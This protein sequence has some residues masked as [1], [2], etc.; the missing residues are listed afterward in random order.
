MAPVELWQRVKQRQGW[1]SH[2]SI[3]LAEQEEWK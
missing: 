2:D 3:T 1:A